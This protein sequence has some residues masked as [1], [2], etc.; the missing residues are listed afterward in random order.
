MKVYS[1]KNWATLYENNRTR[2]LKRLDW[3]P[4]PN[5][6]DGEGYTLILAQQDGPALFGAWMAILQVASR[7]G[8]RGTLLRDTGK[9]HD[10]ISLARLTRFPEDLMSR[11][12]N[13]FAGED[14]QWLEVSD[15]EGD[16]P[17]SASPCDIPAPSCENVASPCPV[18][19]GMEW[20]GTE[21]KKPLPLQRA[22]AWPDS[23]EAVIGQGQFIG[24][25][26]EQCRLFWDTFE[27]RGWI[28][29]NGN[30]ITNWNARL[31]RWMTDW[32]AKTTQATMGQRP[33]FAAT[34]KEQHEKGF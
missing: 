3:V 22:R 4:V 29:A 26:E 15:P 18:R 34:T 19:K 5:N 27:A 11:A 8:K 21:E 2:E 25:P 16:S 7:C 31:R 17:S 30:P 33:R 20:K 32:R 13:F 6:H 1:I 23:V 12:L 10:A 14:M 9:P 24:L 28:D